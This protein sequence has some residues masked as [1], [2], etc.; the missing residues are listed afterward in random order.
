VGS[1]PVNVLISHAL[2]ESHLRALQAID[3]R[4]YLEDV[5][6]EYGA[7][8]RARTRGQE[9]VPLSQNIVDALGWAEVM[10]ALRVLPEL[11][12]LAPRLRWLQLVSAGTDH[13]PDI[14]GWGVLVTNA[15]GIHAATMGEY[16]FGSILAF[17]K[18]LFASYDNQHQR[19]WRRFEFTPAELDGKTMGI[20]GLGHIGLQ[21]ARLAHAF[22][23]RVLAIKRSP[24]ATPPDVDL[25][26]SPGHLYDLLRDSD[27]VVLA[28]PL[29]GETR[30]LIDEAALRAMKASAYLV[31]VS[32]G[33]VVAEGTL[34]RALSER[35]IAGAALDVFERE[36]LPADSP[37]WDLSNV[38]ITPHNAGR[39]ERYNERLASLFADNLRR[40]LAGRPLANV[41][42]L[43]RGY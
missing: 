31:N 19:Q 34:A 12:S 33:G 3:E 18:G 10:L 30:H 27:F 4:I 7:L 42:D 28:V 29:T 15:S 32:R 8:L 17:T 2:E 13:L 39:T 9:T 14:G 40:Y 25:L 21:V 38:L 5:S 36:P 23:M 26:L 20:V 1:E 37:L 24:S 6:Q 41:V 16:V 11:K 22:G 43:T 35:W